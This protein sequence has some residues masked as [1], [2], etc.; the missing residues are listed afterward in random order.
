MYDKFWLATIFLAMAATFPLIVAFISWDGSSGN[1]G[2]GV[3]KKTTLSSR[4][5]VGA[6]TA[7]G[8]FTV[9]ALPVVFWVVV[10][11]VVGV[12]LLVDAATVGELVGKVVGSEIG[13]EE[14]HA[15]NAN[16]KA[17][18]PMNQSPLLHTKSPTKSPIVNL[19]IVTTGCT[20]TRKII[21]A[22]VSIG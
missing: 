4:S 21:S 10:W 11:A 17:A 22:E 5:G 14:E 16:T 8:A 19:R 7:V 15:A 9:A 2:S 13:S 20:S 1:V 3:P 18:K 12:G 6:A